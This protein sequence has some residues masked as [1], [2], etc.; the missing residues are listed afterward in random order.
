MTEKP[1]AESPVTPDTPVQYDPAP[2]PE[3]PQIPP[4]APPP[5]DLLASLANAPKVQTLGNQ[6]PG[7]P[8]ISRT[9]MENSIRQVIQES[10]EFSRAYIVHVS[11][12]DDEDQIQHRTFNYFMPMENLDI[13]AGEFQKFLTSIR[14]EMP[15]QLLPAPTEPAPTEESEG[16]K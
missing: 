10:L 4:P 14:P 5:E 8:R 7:G 6:G 1:K 15:T 3:E 2:V 9:D 13:I 11:F 16:D 12:L